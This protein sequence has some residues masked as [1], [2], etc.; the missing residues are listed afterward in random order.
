[1]D[2][3]TLQLGM[4]VSTAQH[5]L[6]RDVLF[7]LVMKVGHTC[8]KCGG[9]LTRET[10]SIEHKTP[11]LDSEDPLRSFFDIENIAF[12]HFVC[13]VSDA[14]KVNRSPL[15]LRERWAIQKRNCYDPNV[16]RKKYLNKG[17]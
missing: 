1:M 11:W 13:N 10:F 2:K 15:S 16:R 7:S 8:F 6:L 3:K 5:R 4:N 17:Y 12:S 14:R 9:E